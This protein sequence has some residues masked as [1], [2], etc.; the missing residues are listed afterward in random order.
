M[1]F[2]DMKCPECETVI[3]VEHS[4]HE[5]PEYNCQACGSVLERVFTPISFKL[6]GDNGWPSKAFRQKEY[7]RKVNENLDSRKEER[8]REHPSLKLVPNVNGE[9]VEN[10]KEAQAIVKEK[11]S[12]PVTGQ[13]YDPSTFEP[14]IKAEGNK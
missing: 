10:W 13:P 8:L 3:E 12:D 7:W 9:Q 6:V 11:G 4:V 2:Y 5:T 1:A 14:Y